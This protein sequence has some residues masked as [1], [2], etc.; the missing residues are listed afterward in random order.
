MAGGVHRDARPCA[1]MR[2]RE[3]SALRA[4]DES[5]QTS[6][7][8][9]VRVLAAACRSIVSVRAGDITV[10]R[11]LFTLAHELG[12]WDPVVCALRAASEL[13][14][15][16]AR[17]EASRGN[18]GLLRRLQRPRAGAQR[19]FQ[20]SRD[21]GPRRALNSPRARGPRPDRRGMRN[22]EIAQA[23][24]ISTST[25]KVHIRHVFEKLGV[26]TRAEAVARYEMFSEAE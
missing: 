3:S 23:L 6:R 22:H 10:A 24:F 12:A 1:G 25:T 11:R 2:G 17:D 13:A 9:E 19:R 26:R 7:V 18:S 15:G 20:N 4:A 21:T 16:L 8:V 5:E 14:D